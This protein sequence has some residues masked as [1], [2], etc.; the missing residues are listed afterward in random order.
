MNDELLAAMYDDEDDAASVKPETTA[1]TGIMNM[2]ALTSAVRR[3]EKQNAEQARTIRKLELQVKS[4]M[5][6][7]RSSA[8]DIHRLEID[9]DGKIDRH[10]T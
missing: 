4:L 10:T 3:L 1:T 2:P 7:V 9:L 5:R 6:Y 8:Q